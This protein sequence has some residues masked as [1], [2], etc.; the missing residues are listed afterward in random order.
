MV[1][2]RNRDVRHRLFGPSRRADPRQSARVSRLLKRLYVRGLIAKI[3]RSRRWRVTV[4]G[5]AVM[6]AAVRVREEHFP[7]AFMKQAA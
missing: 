2:L 7:E 6:S 3:P 5:Y 1:G 4:L